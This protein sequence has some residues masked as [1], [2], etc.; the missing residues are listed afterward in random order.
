MKA[1]FII[2]VLFFSAFTLCSCKKDKDETVVFKKKVLA[3]YFEINNGWGFDIYVKGKKFIHQSHIPAITGMQ[4]F[5]FKEDAIL[6]GELMKLKIEKN[7]IPP[8][9]TLRELDSLQI[10]ITKK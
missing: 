8:T 4:P 10:K 7:I 5:F 1:L 3:A 6:V 9:I 2:A